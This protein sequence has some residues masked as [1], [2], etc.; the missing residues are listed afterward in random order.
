MTAQII[1]YR[2]TACLDWG[3]IARD[4]W[5]ARNTETGTDTCLTLDTTDYGAQLQRLGWYYAGHKAGEYVYMRRQWQPRQPATV[6]QPKPLPK[7][8]DDWR[9]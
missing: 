6:T 8:L 4:G 1:V 7:Y 9:K 5:H 3:C 2:P